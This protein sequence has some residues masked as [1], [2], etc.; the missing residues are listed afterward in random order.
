LHRDLLRLRRDDQLLARQ[1]RHLLDGAVL[2]PQALVLRYSG[3]I[4]DERLLVVNLGS[5]VN[6]I[7]GP[8]PLLAPVTDGSWVLQWSSDHPAYGGPGI[9]NPLTDKGW[10]ISAATATL[11]KAVKRTS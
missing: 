1:D 10:R 3:P 4:D 11:F 9:I 2:G 5:D 8:E 7:P 6:F